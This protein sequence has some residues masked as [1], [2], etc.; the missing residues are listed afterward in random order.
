MCLWLDGCVFL[1]VNRWIHVFMLHG[2]VR[3]DEFPSK[4]LLFCLLL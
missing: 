4:L 2:K 3:N 1:S